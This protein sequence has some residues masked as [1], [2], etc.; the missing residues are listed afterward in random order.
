MFTY[1]NIHIG[2]RQNRDAISPIFVMTCY[3][4]NFYSRNET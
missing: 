3:I 1:I 2:G 4:Q